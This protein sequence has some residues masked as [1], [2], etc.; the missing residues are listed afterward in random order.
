MIG[1]LG[2]H[3]TIEHGHVLAVASSARLSCL[4]LLILLLTLLLLLLLLL[5]LSMS[6]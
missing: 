2:H 5:L 1:R 4:R 6:R 3:A